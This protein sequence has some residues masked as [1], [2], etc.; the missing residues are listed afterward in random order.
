MSTAS[1][2]LVH[3]L[4]DVF[5]G[6]RV[7]LGALVS[8]DGARLWVE[9]RS[10]PDGRC[11]GG[12]AHAN[13]VQMLLE[14]FRAGAN[15]QSTMEIGPRVFFD[16]VRA[17]PAG[18]EPVAWVSDV[19]FPRRRDDEGVGRNVP[20]S[21]AE[22]GRGIF[23]RFD[24]AKYVRRG[25]R[26]SDHPGVLPALAP[27][28][29]RKVAHWVWGGDVRLLLLEPVRASGQRRDSE[30]ERVSTLFSAYRLHLDRNAI[31]D[32]QLI[33]YLLPGM[34]PPQRHET[35]RDLLPVARV[36]DLTSKT[37]RN[38]LISE[39]RSIG[40]SAQRETN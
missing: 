12:Q 27:I 13:T 36:V 4:T 14:Q 16:P 37:S 20:A 28:H 19:L 11:L 15:E 39:I 22:I 7:P 33:A 9:N 10:L 1:Y 26:P 5:V 40:A 31:A 32:V 24:V 3:Y 38:D 34:K 25:F 29:L 2:R 18:A 17:I 8:A 30:V 6:A 35:E 21:A 23:S